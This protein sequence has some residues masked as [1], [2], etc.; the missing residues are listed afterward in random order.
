MRLFWM[1]VPLMMTATATGTRLNCVDISVR[2][3]LILCPCQQ[4][5]ASD[6][7]P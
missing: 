5:I 4:H 1:G 3:F 6:P 7:Q 2:G